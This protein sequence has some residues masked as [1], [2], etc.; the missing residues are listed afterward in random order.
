MDLSQALGGYV[1]IDLG[2]LQG[3]VAEDLLDASQIGAALE[4]VGGGRVAEAVR[5]EI[6]NLP[7]LRDPRMDDPPR[8]R[9]VQAASACAEEEGG[10]TVLG[11]ECG[12]S[13]AQ[14]ILDSAGSRLS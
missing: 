4:E 9:G 7:Y 10:A 5:S 2:R 11:R 1:R 14:P 6:G 12:T 13:G 3:R 8:A